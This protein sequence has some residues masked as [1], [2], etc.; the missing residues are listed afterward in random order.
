VSSFP[1]QDRRRDK[2]ARLLVRQALR[3]FTPCFAEAKSRQSRERF[4]ARGLFRADVIQR[5]SNSGRLSDL[6]V[7]YIEATRVERR[8][9]V[10]RRVRCRPQAHPQKRRGCE[11]NKN[12]SEAVNSNDVTSRRDPM[13][14]NIYISNATND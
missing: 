12:W 1:A 10:C 4:A 7:H 8:A 2:T 3:D 6:P 5:R 11:W 13:I 14:L 9:F